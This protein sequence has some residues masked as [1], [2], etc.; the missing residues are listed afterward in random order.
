MAGNRSPFGF[1]PIRREGASGGPTIVRYRTEDAPRPVFVGDVVELVSGN[2]VR[3][4]GFPVSAKAVGVVVGCL[5]PTINDAFGDTAVPITLSQPTRGPFIAT[6]GGN[7]F[8]DVNTDPEQV[9]WVATDGTADAS[10]LHKYVSVTAGGITAAGP[11]AFCARTGLSPSFVTD[12]CA[13]AAS[14]SHPLVVL[15]FNRSQRPNQPKE[16]GLFCEGVE[17]AFAKTAFNLITIATASAP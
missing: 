11:S 4:L 14:L 3:S 17:V 9:Y 10:W 7:M 1:K 2:I 8:V 6:S 12:T 5:R 13:A 16:P 15:G